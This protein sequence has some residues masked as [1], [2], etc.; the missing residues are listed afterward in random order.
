MHQLYPTSILFI[1]EKDLGQAVNLKKSKIFFSEN[2]SHAEH[3][4]I[5]NMLDVLG[6]KV[7]WDRDEF[8]LPVPIPYFYILT[9]YPT[10]IQRG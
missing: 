10:R 5:A 3:N 8:Y 4:S 7:G 9:Y 2:V 6:M 1:Y